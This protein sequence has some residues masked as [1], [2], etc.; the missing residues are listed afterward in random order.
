METK[1]EEKNG[2]GAEWPLGAAKTKH[3]ACLG[4]MTGARP[5]AVLEV[6]ALR[7]KLLDLTCPRGELAILQS[8]VSVS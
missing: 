7:C 5:V 2:K 8:T 4:S 1:G 6:H 3:V